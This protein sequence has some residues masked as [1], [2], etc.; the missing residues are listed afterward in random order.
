MTDGG[1]VS[2]DKGTVIELIPFAAA[3]VT[4][5]KVNRSQVITAGNGTYCFVPT[6]IDG[7]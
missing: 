2:A 6:H 3:M 1:G 4:G 7:A 5:R